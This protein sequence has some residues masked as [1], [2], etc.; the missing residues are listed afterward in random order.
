MV[1]RRR[2]RAVLWGAQLFRQACDDE[3]AALAGAYSR[4]TIIAVCGVNCYIE[5]KFCR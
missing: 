4:R 5:M 2:S 1:A 3:T